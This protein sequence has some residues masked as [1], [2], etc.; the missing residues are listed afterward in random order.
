VSAVRFAADSRQVPMLDSDT[1]VRSDL[2]IRLILV[3]GFLL[4]APLYFARPSLLLD[5]ARVALNIGARS[6]WQLTQPLDYDQ[7]APLLFL[8]FGKA[9]S[10]VGGVNEYTL[11]LLPFIAGA[12]LPLLVYVV[13]RRVLDARLGILGA[14]LTALSPLVLQYVRQ[15]K[16]Y[17]LDGAVALGIVWLTL[18]WAD[19]PHQG[20][21]T[22]RGALAAVLSVWLSTTAVFVLASAAVVLWCVLP[23]YGPCRTRL[24]RVG[25]ACAA[26]FATA[27]LWIYR[28][29]AR[30]WYM[31]QFW[32]GSVLSVWRPG[33]AG[34]AWQGIREL[35]F[36]TFVGGSTEPPLAP[37][38]DMLVNGVTAALLVL[39]GIGVAVL[40]RRRGTVV[41][42]LLVGPLIAALG[43]SL[44][45][46]YPTAARVMLFGV[47]SLILVAAAGVIAFSDRLSRRF[48]PIGVAALCVPL[49]ALPLPLDLRLVLHPRAF[50]DVRSAV[51]ELERQR[52]AGEP[53]YV[54]AAALP[55]WTFYTTDWTAPDRERLARMAA[56]GS[57]G[58]AGFENAPPRGRAIRLGEAEGMV[59][60]W[61]GG[62]E[63]VGVHHGAQ[64][65][66]GVGLVQANPDTNWTILEAERV[67]A[68]ARGAGS[69]WA[70]IAHSFGL[71]RYLLPAAEQCVDVVYKREAVLLIR[72]VHPELPCRNLPREAF[73]PP[74]LSTA[75][76]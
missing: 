27:Y 10:V 25:A 63:I 74:D 36:Q 43:A 44:A 62:T 21:A 22:W 55:A 15:V 9:A 19:R 32:E 8:W 70:L 37:A 75:T 54:F 46:F 20:G 67:R 4:Q 61:A 42:G 49:I 76:R 52:I 3:L 41:T 7:T 68:A 24:I 30:N 66:S 38:N 56:I 17:T 2:L 59:F 29:A 28:P 51:A 31:Q 23:R 72:L 35:F 39:A 69:V 18:N 60:P 57:S 64:W 6:W 34:R 58:G 11:R 12:S 26:S 53:V 1:R 5:E 14:A 50:E 48:R 71:E 40:W 33:V 73:M 13:G 65:R 47:P 16:P 45:G